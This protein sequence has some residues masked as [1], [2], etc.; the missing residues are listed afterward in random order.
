MVYRYD[1]QSLQF[2]KISLRQ[3]VLGFLFIGFLFSSLGFTG[4]IK[5]NNFVEKI[6]VIVRLNNSF[7]PEEVREEIV[8]LNIDHHTL[9]L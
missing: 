4:A 3:Y 6:P 8:K 1:K 2:K 7:T 9:F 5:F